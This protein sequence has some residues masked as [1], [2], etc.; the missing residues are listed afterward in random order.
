MNRIVHK[1]KIDAS[2]FFLRTFHFVLVLGFIHVHRKKT[3]KE[4]IP[5]WLRVEEEMRWTDQRLGA[6]AQAHQRTEN[7]VLDVHSATM[8]L[9]I[10]LEA[11]SENRSSA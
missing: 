9:Q 4:A 8:E 1:K 7:P 6:T 10:F 2:F 5:V 11:A 3:E